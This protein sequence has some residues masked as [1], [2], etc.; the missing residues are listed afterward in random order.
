SDRADS[1]A[2]E[3]IG[4]GP[5]TTGPQRHDSRG[6]RHDQPGSAPPPGGGAHRTG[7]R[8]APGAGRPRAGATSAP[9]PGD[10]QPRSDEGGHRAAARVSDQGP[11]PRRRY[12][13]CRSARLRHWA[14]PAE[15][16]AALRG[17]LYD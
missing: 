17:L 3:E 16:G 10:E 14:G 4:P 12:R 7:P 6:A 9:E 13:A 15:Y 5:G 8:L 1:R 11:A 2:S